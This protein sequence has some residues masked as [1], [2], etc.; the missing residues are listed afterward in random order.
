MIP[1]SYSASENH[2]S[3]RLG[4][5]VLG[6]NAPGVVSDGATWV[7]VHR[8]WMYGPHA[9]IRACVRDLLLE[10]QSDRHLVG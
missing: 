10:W 5:L 9:T 3:W 8:C 1:W 7:I 4:P 6:W 2:R